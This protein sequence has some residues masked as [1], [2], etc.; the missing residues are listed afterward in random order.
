MSETKA[1]NLR[2]ESRAYS[3]LHFLSAAEERSKAEV[4]QEALDEYAAR[5]RD[6]LQKYANDVAA[7]AG[8]SLPR[9]GRISGSRAEILAARA[10]GRELVKR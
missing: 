10:G 7:A 8:V 3:L 5:H 6:R 4:V 1:A 9:A 2:L